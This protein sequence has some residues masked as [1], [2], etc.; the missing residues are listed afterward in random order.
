MGSPTNRPDVAFFD[1]A[2][3]R[4]LDLGAAG[5][6]RGA[7]IIIRD[8][9]TRYP[10]DAAAWSQLS[11]LLIRRKDFRGALAA[12]R[13]ALT[14]DPLH[15]EAHVNAGIATRGIGDLEASQ[16]YLEEAARITPNDP[17]AHLQLGETLVRL[18]R[19]HDAI[20]A[21]LRTI[22]VAHHEG[23]RRDVLIE[24]SAER[25]AA[26]KPQPP[27]DEPLRSL[28]DGVRWITTGDLLQAYQRIERARD[29]ASDNTDIHDA[30]SALLGYVWHLHARLTPADPDADHNR[31]GGDLIH[32]SFGP[33]R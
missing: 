23:N 14:R 9:C 32:V 25:I 8:L 26:I 11:A 4:A 17:D 33:L 20:T 10:T 21:L 13:D 29:A 19:P 5:D 12:A 3:N 6:L 28:H 30:A 16:R 27:L 18:R 24:R 2:Y 22:V 31:H 15:A 7:I 1:D